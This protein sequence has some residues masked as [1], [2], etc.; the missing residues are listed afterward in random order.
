[1]R[2]EEAR[3]VEDDGVPA[4]RWRKKEMRVTGVPSLWDNDENGNEAGK[5]RERPRGVLVTERDMTVLRWISEQFAV[6]ADVIRWL[7]GGPARSATAGP[8]R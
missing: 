1:V 5:A 4:E 3:R 6:R 8:A 2:Q 7:L